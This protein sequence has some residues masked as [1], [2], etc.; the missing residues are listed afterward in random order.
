[1]ARALGR[2]DVRAAIGERPVTL[3]A[4]GKAAA[5]M[6][7]AWLAA[8]G[9]GVEAGLVAAPGRPADADLGALE[10]VRAGHPEPDGGSLAAARRALAL[11]ARAADGGVLVLLLSGGASAALAAPAPGV[12]LDDKVRATR[13]LLEAGVAI[14]RINCVRKHLSAVKGGWLAA[15]AGGAA[16]TLAISDVVGPA[17]DDPA[18]IGSGPTAP[19]PT[20]YG[21]AL[22]VVAAPRIR[23][24]FP[25]AALRALEE[26][27]QGRRAETPKPGDARLRRAR[28]F[29]IGNREDALAAAARRAAGLGYAVTTLAAP[30][31]GEA[32]AAAGPQVARALAAAG[33]RPACILSAGET[34]VEVRGA[35]RGGRNQEFALAAVEPL[36]ALP[37]R[38]ALASVG[39][40][41]I[42]GPT[43][44]AGAVVDSTTLARAREKGLPAPGRYLD[45]NDSY[46][47]FE[48][49]GGLLR[50]GPTATNVGDLQVLLIDDH[51]AA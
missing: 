40:D 38:A 31:V 15:A 47:F 24:A 20:T 50:L 5:P 6:A 8:A 29:V 4:A 34:T 11:A 51:A 32:R 12:S 49:L 25:P 16:V 42:D 28:T 45:N 36:A 1:M 43:D 14:D 3:V 19:D 13:A 26:G 7:A 46:A 2:G 23:A 18:V 41:G 17:P 48:T 22:D 37:G 44:A 21:D 10:W 9:T 35:G 39:T 30:V 27:R 33:R